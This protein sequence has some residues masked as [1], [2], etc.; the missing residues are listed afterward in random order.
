MRFMETRGNK[1]VGS[2]MFLRSFFRRGRGDAVRGEDGG[3][4][5]F[6]FI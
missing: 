5:D 1:I 6:S 3:D 2:D 4:F